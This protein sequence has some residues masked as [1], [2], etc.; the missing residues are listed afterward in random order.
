[1][2]VELADTI[3]Q[4]LQVVIGHWIHPAESR[5][6]AHNYIHSMPEIYREFVSL[7]MMSYYLV[8]GNSLGYYLVEGNSLGYYLVEG[9]SL[10]YYLVEGNSLGYYLVE[11][12]SLGY[13]SFVH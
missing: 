3:F 12:N 11:G 9:N 4:K 7:L 13:Y 8:E 6:N 5:R 10:G 2:A 1:M